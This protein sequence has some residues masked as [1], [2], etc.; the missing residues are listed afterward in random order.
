MIRKRLDVR[1][2]LASLPLFQKLREDELVRLAHAARVVRAAR[3]EMLFNKG[4]APAGF[5]LV[6]EGQVKLALS[7]SHGVEKVLQLF[8]P[9]QTFGEA[10]MFLERPYPVHGECLAD[11]LLLHVPRQ[12]VFEAIESDPGFA[13]R[14]L[15]GLAVRLH[16]L[17]SD[18]EA[19]S[20]R[21][22]AQRLVGY[23]LNLSESQA[24]P[25]AQVSLPTSKHIVASRL[26]LTPETLSRLLH[27][28][29]ADQLISVDGRE[30]T[31]RDVERLRS[32][33]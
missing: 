29:A 25:E 21:S 32:Y 30:V 6:V 13:R 5:Y 14:I 16:Q 19:Y 2:T 23:L 33:A 7:S 22:A 8:G 26:N 12:A 17:V 27:T 24:L 11:S 28:L 31:I 10:V 20:M 18:V 3:G 9:G 4:D 1:G 15:G